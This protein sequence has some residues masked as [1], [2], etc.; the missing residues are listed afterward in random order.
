MNFRRLLLLLLIVIFVIPFDVEAKDYKVMLSFFSNGGEVASGNVEIISGVIFLKNDVKSDVIYNSNQTISH[1]NSLDGNTTFTLKKGTKSQTKNKEWFTTDYTNG[2]KVYFSNSKTYKVKDIIKSLG[3]DTSYFEKNG[4]PIEIDLKANYKKNVSVQSIK[5]SYSNVKIKKGKTI[6]LKAIISPS[7][8]TDKNLKWSSNNS[9]IVSVDSN[10]K[11]KGLKEGTAIVTVK[12]SNGKTAE[13]KISVK[14]SSSSTNENKQVQI[15]Y[16]INGGK[17]ASVHSKSIT[18]VNSIIYYN[19]NKYIQNVKWGKKLGSGGLVNY[20]SSSFINI[21]KVGN[22]IMKDMEWNTKSDGSGKSYSQ[23]KIYQASDFCDT[24]CTITLYANW[25]RNLKSISSCTKNSKVSSQSIEEGKIPTKT[26]KGSVGNWSTIGKYKISNY[27]GFTSDGS[28]YFYLV[29][30]LKEKSEE[31]A[32]RIHRI[33]ANETD[34]SY[35]K[36]NNSDI[37]DGV[38]HGN[39]IAYMSNGTNALIGIASQGAMITYKIVGTTLS[40]KKIIIFNDE[41]GN[42]VNATGITFVKNVDSSAGIFIKTGRKIYYYLIPYDINTTD[43]RINIKGTYKF[44]LEPYKGSQDETLNQSIAYHNGYLY[45]FNQYYISN[46]YF[47]AYDVRDNCSGNRLVM[48]D[49]Y[50][51]T[52][53]GYSYREVEG[54]AWIGDTYYVASMWKKNGQ[55]GSGITKLIGY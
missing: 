27:Q 39:G 9:K 19:K 31:K 17:L 50:K 4:N 37:L 3:I 29:E 34:N 44:D 6:S 22:I 42:R 24:T 35:L 40:D 18:V 16:H 28:N 7:I 55:V 53:F 8:A 32:V 5:L 41:N 47:D 49:I 23:N 30:N 26:L 46:T 36:Y 2:K 51:P 52:K 14:K 25:R 12:S 15:I 21:E 43:L 54:I 13:C 1:I 38:I 11:V 45:E 20:N 48:R 10:G 33:S